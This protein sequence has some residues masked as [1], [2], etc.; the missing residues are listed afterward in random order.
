MGAT[1]SVS[2]GLTPE[3]LA[4]AAFTP[5][6]SLRHFL[7]E[8]ERAAGTALETR[9]ELGCWAPDSILGDVEAALLASS[10]PTLMNEVRKAN[11]RR[12]AAMANGYSTG[13]A[14]SAT[15]LVAR[16]AAL[17]RLRGVS[18]TSDS[19]HDV[20]PEPSGAPDWTFYAEFHGL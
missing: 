9:R 8:A 16:E 4:A 12:Q 10:L 17:E 5:H 11:Q 1:T 18:A 2:A 6:G 14:A 19:W 3:T 7:A 20:V 15:E 13:S